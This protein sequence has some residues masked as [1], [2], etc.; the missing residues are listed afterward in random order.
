MIAFL[1]LAAATAP[2]DAATQ[3]DFLC[4]QLTAREIKIAPEGD[5][6][7]SYENAHA[8]YLGRL[9]ARDHTVRWTVRWED[10]INEAV[11][12]HPLSEAQYSA[13]LFECMDYYIDEMPDLAPE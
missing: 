12:L 10:R 1:M 6:R 8:Y 5:Q 11:K 4:A 2:M 13:Q 3:S 9:S 7:A